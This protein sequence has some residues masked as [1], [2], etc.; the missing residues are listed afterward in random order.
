LR[1]PESTGTT[2]RFAP[3]DPP[4]GWDITRNP[5]VARIV[6]DRR[7]QFLLILPNQIIFWTVIFV[8]LLGTA[9]PG[10]NFGTA[11]TWYVWF[12]LV[13]VLMVVVGRAWCAMCPFGGFAE[14][15]PP[16]PAGAWTGPEVP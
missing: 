4:R 10:L 5:R 1:A 6:R 11:I 12:C 15:I 7:F 9:D 14:W 3:S 8:G 16:D 13:F 2:A